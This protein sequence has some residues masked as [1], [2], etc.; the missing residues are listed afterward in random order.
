MKEYNIKLSE[1]EI[2]K[3]M[4]ILF[5]MPFKEVYELIGKLNDQLVNQEIT[6]NNI[7]KQN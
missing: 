4:E 7:L 3:I 2:K 5:E 1:D 6:R